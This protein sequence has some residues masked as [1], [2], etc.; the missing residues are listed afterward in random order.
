MNI[1]EFNTDGIVLDNGGFLA[2][3][4]LKVSDGNGF[5]TWHYYGTPV[6]GDTL[7]SVA[8]IQH[9][10]VTVQLGDLSGAAYDIARQSAVDGLN[11]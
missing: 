3:F 1:E 8:C 5:R 2:S 9:D 10:A 7:N 6:L 4:R 11:A